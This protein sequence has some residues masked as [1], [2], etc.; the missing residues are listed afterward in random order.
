MSGPA[1]DHAPDRT[2]DEGLADGGMA[3]EGPTGRRVSSGL[4]AV[5]AVGV[6][7]SAAAVVVVRAAQDPSA[8]RVVDVDAPLPEQCDEVPSSALRSTVTDADGNRLGAALVGGGNTGPAVVLRHGASQTLCDWLTWADHLQA[9]T[10]AEVLLFD[11]RGSGS[12]A[13]LASAGGGDSRDAADLVAAARGLGSTAGDRRGRPL[14]TV[15]SSRGTRSA[16]AALEDLG[17]LEGVEHCGWAAVSPVLSSTVAIPRPGAGQHPRLTLVWEEGRTDVAAAVP[18]LAAAAAAARWT[19]V[20]EAVDTDDHSLA[21]VRNHREAAAA[22]T[23]AV[24]A[25]AD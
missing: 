23:A 16:H 1:G 5:L 14:V 4:A 20:E 10:G 17:S 3:D 12:S 24:R 22:V 8:A 6:V 9:S 21:L 15:S 18:A 2:P 7:T 13:H 25:C 19:V 11:R